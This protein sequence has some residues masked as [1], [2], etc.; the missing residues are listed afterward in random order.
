VWGG[1]LL[2][3]ATSPSSANS[4]INETIAI[5]DIIIGNRFRKDLGDIDSLARSIQE[6]GLL[7]LVVINEHNE[8]VA[9]QR[10]VEACKKLGWTKI[11]CR[12]V[13]ILDVIKGEFHENSARKDFTF[14]ERDQSI[15][16]QNTQKPCSK[17]HV[18]RY[19]RYGRYITY[20]TGSIFELSAYLLLL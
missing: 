7:H 3:M 10:R 13:N 17:Q 11:P 20:L 19:G 14:S 9:G 1:V 5:E 16:R 18:G 2:K 12:I 8:L 4:T 15:V 6:V